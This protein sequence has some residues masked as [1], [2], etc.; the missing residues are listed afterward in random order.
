MRPKPVT[1]P[2]PA[3]RCV[4]HAEIDA[5]MA[6]EFVEFFEGAFVEQQI[7]ALARGE[8]AGFVFSL[9]ALEPPPASASAS[10]RRSLPC[11][12]GVLAN[13]CG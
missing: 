8:L 7:D 11:G 6:D 1:K 9:A 12:R 4:L 2:S 10:R 5:A 13:L 3:G